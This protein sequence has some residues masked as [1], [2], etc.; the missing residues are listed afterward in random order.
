MIHPFPQAGEYQPAVEARTRGSEYA[1]LLDRVR[2]A[3][4]LRRRPLSSSLRIAVNGIALAAGWAV[5]ALVGDSWWQLLTAVFL[6]VSFTQ[7]GFLGHDAGHQ[8]IFRT[9][10]ANDL[11]G[12]VHGNLAIG[13]GYGWWVDKHRRHHAH[14]NQEGLDPD[15]S[16]EV[17][18]FTSTQA[19]ARQRVGAFLAHHQAV[20]LIPLMLLEGINLHVASARA[21][22]RPGCPRRGREASLLFLHLAAYLAV[23][24]VVLSPG[25]ALVFMAVHQGLFGLYLGCSFAPNHKG[26]PILA[27]DD[28]SDFLRRQVLTARNVSGGP[29]I[30][31]LLGGLNYQIEHHLFPSMPRTALRRARPIVRAYCAEIGL[32]YAE[33]TLFASYRQA[34]GYVRRI[35]RVAGRP[36]HPQTP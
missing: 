29:V 13:L 22:V 36:P 6:A 5:F 1:V 23:V 31:L 25:K 33:T 10:R 2:R 18:V 34:L 27:R 11:V 17:I 26:M 8:Q 9:R 24:F 3:G 35:G 14:P 7:L 19:R 20:F 28:A 16:G 21:L 30:G 12:L 4:L 15:I 32:P